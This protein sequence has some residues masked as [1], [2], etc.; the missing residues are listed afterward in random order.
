MADAAR[1]RGVRWNVVGGLPGSIIVQPLVSVIM[2]AYNSEQYI[3]ESI[4][5]VLAQTYENWELLVVDDGSTDN[6]GDIVNRFATTEF[7]IKY[8]FQQ[9]GRQAK[10]RNTGIEKSSGTLIA[11]LDSDDLWLPDKL[12]RQVTTLV[13]M[14]ADV[15][16]SN[17]TIIYEPGAAPGATEFPIVSGRVEGAKMFDL[18]LLQNRIPVQS[19]LLGRDIFK[20]AGPF[21]E[22]VAY[23]ACEDYELW[24]K[25]AVHGAMFYGINEKLIKYRRHPTATTH[26]DSNW[27]KP[28]L[29]VVLHHIAQG[30]LDEK[31][32]RAR[33]RGLYRDVIAALLEE[34][35]LTEARAY[36]NE[37]SAW[38]KSGLVTS[39]Q[40][41]LLR[42]APRGFNFFSR[43]CLYRT[44]WHLQKLT[45]K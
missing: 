16:Y 17:G 18:L 29:R 43:E 39:I 11:F 12:E 25:L 34:G 27:L 15:V 33:L 4:Q 37:F 8:I 14:N 40:N 24:L 42:V 44:E 3:A 45:G 30:T 6:T 5:S 41:V 38:D 28:M 20:K 31:K 9:N 13:E 19:V 32:K 7:R 23:H 2:P 26:K 1:K 35:D 36:M 21:D 10:A 22:C